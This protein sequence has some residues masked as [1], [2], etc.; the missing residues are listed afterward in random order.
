[1]N[2]VVLLEVTDLCVSIADKPV[3]KNLNLV[4]REGE[5][6]VILGPNGSGKSTLIKT[7][8]GFQYVFRSSSSQVRVRPIP[9]F[10]LVSASSPPAPSSFWARISPRALYLLNIGFPSFRLREELFCLVEENEKSNVC[11]I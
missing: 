6:H 1:M 3:L 9:S 8:M 2:S 4:I 7:I 10:F 5:N 11:S